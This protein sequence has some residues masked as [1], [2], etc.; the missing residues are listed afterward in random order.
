MPELVKPKVAEV[1]P[2]VLNEDKSTNQAVVVDPTQIRRPWRSTF[3]TAF[4][5]LVALA[6]LVPF[7]VAGIYDGSADYPAVVGQVLAVAAAVSRVMA[8]PQVERFLRTFLPWLA[9]AP[10]A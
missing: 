7:V 10:K 2:V 8:L 6:T 1:V 4:Q 9:A 3:R 5:A